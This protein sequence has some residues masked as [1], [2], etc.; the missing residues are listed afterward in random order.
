MERVIFFSA[1]WTGIFLPG[2][3][4]TIGYFFYYR[5]SFN[6][7]HFFYIYLFALFFFV[8]DT[9]FS[10]FEGEMKAG[11]FSGKGKFGFGNLDKYDG[12]FVDGR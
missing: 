6:N 1:F 11:K 10:R 7:R 8:C 3:L 9:F 4:L 5:K 12:T 2:S